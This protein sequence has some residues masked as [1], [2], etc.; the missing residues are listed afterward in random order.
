[1]SAAGPGALDPGDQRLV[2]ALT[3]ITV[4]AAGGAAAGLVLSG[5]AQ[6]VVGGV[7]VGL[8]V[9]APVLRVGWLAVGWARQG[10]WRFVGAALTLFAA[11]GVGA[12][13]ALVS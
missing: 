12:F 8:V 10:D 4:L 2:W 6:T 3:A 1:M 5:R 13:V 11:I 7:A 9:A